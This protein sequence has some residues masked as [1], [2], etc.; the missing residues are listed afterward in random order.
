MEHS[1]PLYN[2]AAVT[3]K[4]WKGEKLQCRDRQVAPL[5]R[6]VEMKDGAKF[7]P[8]IFAH[9][10]KRNRNDV[11]LTSQEQQTTSNGNK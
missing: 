8:T 11:R 1:H 7:A 4:G 2:S 10:V 6:S 9:H 3:T 5:F